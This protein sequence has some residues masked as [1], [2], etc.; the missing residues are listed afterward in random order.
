[1]TDI[2]SPVGSH[3]RGE[4][5]ATYLAAHSLRHAASASQL[6]SIGAPRPPLLRRHSAELEAFSALLPPPIVQPMQGS[7]FHKTELCPWFG[8]AGVCKYGADCQVSVDP[9]ASLRLVVCSWS[10]GAPIARA[11]STPFLAVWRVFPAQSCSHPSHDWGVRR[12]SY[13]ARQPTRTT[14]GELASASTRPRRRGR[15]RPR[16]DP[17]PFVVLPQASSPADRSG[18]R[19]VERQSERAAPRANEVLSLALRL[20]HPA[21]ELYAASRL[22]I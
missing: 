14:P 1:M 13:H 8:E 12:T 11:G 20:D 17:Y 21:V 6:S 5:V 2:L 18:T 15:G 9:V 3:P 4:D 22:A 16:S 7:K 19:R 10:G